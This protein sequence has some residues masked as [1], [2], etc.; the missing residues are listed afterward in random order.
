MSW[1][2][3]LKIQMKYNFNK[4]IA[5]GR[6]EDVRGLSNTPWKRK[7][8]KCINL[9]YDQQFWNSGE[10]MNCDP[11]SIWIT[12]LWRNF[13]WPCQTTFLS[14]H[15]AR[16]AVVDRHREHSCVAHSKSIQYENEVTIQLTPEYS[17][18]L[19]GE[20]WRI[21]SSSWGN[22]SSAPTLAVSIR[23]LVQRYTTLTLVLLT[24]R[25]WWA[26]NNVSRWQ[27]GFNSASKWLNKYNH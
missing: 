7:V 16:Y 27:M 17:F 20:E 12:A 21:Y 25:I 4:K 22:E 23:L 19:T 14:V 11:N 26:S 18:L 15:L 8:A 6:G 13:F 24:W 9:H 5:V 3:Q 10:Y 2:G 1:T